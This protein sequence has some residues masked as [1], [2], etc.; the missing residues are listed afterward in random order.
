MQ[1]P[2]IPTDNLYKFLSLSGIAIFIFSIVYPVYL[3]KQLDDL[4]NETTTSIGLMEIE[5]EFLSKKLNE[6]SEESS[7]K[8]DE[9]SKDCDYKK[10]NNP[11]K[12]LKK[13]LENLYDEKN[14]DSLKF[15]YQYKDE[16]FRELK[17][18]KENQKQLIEMREL[19]HQHN[20][21]NYQIK[22]K[23]E[24]NREL[25]NDLKTIHRFA[26]LGI[27]LGIILAI[28]GFYLWYNKVQK[29]L[30]EKIRL[31]LKEKS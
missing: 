17:K 15:I 20:I 22:R 13:L 24:I 14:C 30:D 29:L 11:E 4:V 12:D 2:N 18:L 5:T 28:I 9:K 23:I 7:K 3:S 8:T 31:E 16:L 25:A 26:F 21:N 10:E 19:N 6:L 1:M 27:V